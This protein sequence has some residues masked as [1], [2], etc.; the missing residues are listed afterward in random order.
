MAGPELS[1]QLTFWRGHLARKGVVGA[2]ANPS[3]RARTLA[4]LARRFGPALVLAPVAGAEAQGGGPGCGRAG[5]GRPPRAR[6]RLPPPRTL[7]AEGSSSPATTRSSVLLPLP[8]GPMT[9]V[10]EP[11]RMGAAFCRPE[12]WAQLNQPAAG[13]APQTADNREVATAVA[14][15]ATSAAGARGDGRDGDDH[16]TVVYVRFAEHPT[17]VDRIA[18][19]VDQVLYSHAHHLVSPSPTGPRWFDPVVV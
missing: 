4:F 15:A 12:S 14:V 2:N 8:F 1:R 10:N 3:L 6:G 13:L 11:A 5:G 16:D 7:P 18:R 19:L 17:H 9:T